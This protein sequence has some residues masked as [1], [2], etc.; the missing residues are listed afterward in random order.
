MAII[1]VSRHRKILRSL[2]SNTQPITSYNTSEVRMIPIGH[3]SEW[4]KANIDTKREKQE[5]SK[6]IL[7]VR[8]E[9]R[10]LMLSEDAFS[11]IKFNVQV[12]L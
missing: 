6:D 2:N 8:I 10:L 3:E 11:K 12:S 1:T 9:I 4:M 7:P 5:V